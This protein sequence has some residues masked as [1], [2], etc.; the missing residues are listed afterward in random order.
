VGVWRLYE[1][2]GVYD[3]WTPDHLWGPDTNSNSNAS[4]VRRVGLNR[5]ENHNNV[6][7]ADLHVGQLGADEVLS[8]DRWFDGRFLRADEP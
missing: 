6:L 7:F 4:D 5:H 8:R 3:I 1:A 2:A